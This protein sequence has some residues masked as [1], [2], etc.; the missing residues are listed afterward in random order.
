MAEAAAKPTVVN[1]K[2]EALVGHQWGLGEGI[3]NAE[4]SRRREV[5]RLLVDRIERRFDRVPRGKRRECPFKST[6]GQGKSLS[7]VL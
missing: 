1:E 5:Y 6:C 3:A 2:E 7:S 4:P